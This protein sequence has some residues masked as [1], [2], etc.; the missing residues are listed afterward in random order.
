MKGRAPTAKTRS[1]GASV[2]RMAAAAGASIPANSGWV[3]AS[4]VE[5][6]RGAAKTGAPRASARSDRASLAADAPT[7]RLATMASF[8]TAGSVSSSASSCRP[9]AVAWRTMC[10]GGGTGA[11]PSS[12]R[13]D[14]GRLTN[15]G[16]P[17]GPAASWKARRMMVPSSRSERTS[18]VQR[19]TGAARPTRSPARSGSASMWP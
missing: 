10:D 3:G 4:A 2:A 14:I 8:P 1:Y 16:P 5:P 6:C 15:T 11:S 18:W 12:S 13:V 9:P 7:S 19:L 17:G